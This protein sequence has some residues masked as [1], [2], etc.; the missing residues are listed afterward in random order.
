MTW[1]VTPDRFL[2]LWTAAGNDEFPFPL[3]YRSASMWE[4]EYDADR[5]AADEWRRQLADPRLDHA[6]RILQAGELAVEMYGNAGTADIRV[7]GG[8]EGAFA[9]LARQYASGDIQIV[10]IQS[11]ILARAVVA[12]IPAAP[13][14]HEQARAAS[15]RELTEPTATTSV[16][17]QIGESEPRALRRLL[18][19]DR[20][21]AGSIRLL[22]PNAHGRLT[23]ESDIGWF[24][25]VDDGRYM[26]SPGTDTRVVPATNDILREELDRRIDR[27]R[28]RR[29]QD[30]PTPW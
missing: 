30:A 15:I 6:I 13:R 3:R 28:A 10:P 1:H 4:D 8:K 21:G 12:Q 11:S 7:R 2:S 29:R 17:Q 27:A 23:T 25:V 14:G 20:S 22:A 24:D 9:V 26:F 18:L 19:R 16:R 5:H